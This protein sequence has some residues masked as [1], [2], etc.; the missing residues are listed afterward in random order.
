M[1]RMWLFGAV[2]FLLGSTSSPRAANENESLTLLCARFKEAAATPRAVKQG[3][4]DA[5][6][7][8]GVPTSGIIEA[9]AVL[10]SLRVFEAAVCAK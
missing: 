3:W 9:R 2:M 5:K 7:R 4:L 8:P 1:M 6:G 10:E